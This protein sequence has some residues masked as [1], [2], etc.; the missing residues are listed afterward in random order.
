RTELTQVAA[1]ELGIAP[2]RV[3]LVMADTARVPDDGGTSGSRTTPSTV[4][5]VRAAAAELARSA[6]SEGNGR[7]S[8]GDGQ[9]GVGADHASAGDHHPSTISHR[10]RSL[11]RVGAAALVTGAHHYTSDL[12]RPGML[13]GKIVR[14]AAFGAKLVSAETGAVRAMPGV[15]VVQ[16][17]D[18]LGV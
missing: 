5:Q 17:G 1:E 7:W 3:Q 8:M 4:P 11:P 13:Y 15:V 6:G 9:G 12:R 18:F 10:P 14:P 16:E 2:E